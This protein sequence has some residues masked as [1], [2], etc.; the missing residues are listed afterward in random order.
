MSGWAGFSDEELRRIQQKDSTVSAPPVRGRKPASGNRSRQQLQRERALQSAAQKNVGAESLVL[1]REQQLTKPS[2]REEPKPTAPATTPTV[3]QEVQQKPAIMKH[4]E[5]DQP[6]T[7]EETPVVK[8]LDKQEIELREKTRL[9]QLQQEQKII[10]ERNKRKKALL[11]KTIAEKK[12]YE[13]A[14]AEYV[15]AKLDLHKKT[16]VKEQLTEHLCAIIQQNELRKAHKL[17]EL[18]QQLQLQASEEELERQ[19]EEERRNLEVQKDVEKE[20]GS[21]ESQEVKVESTKNCG[22]KEKET[23]KEETGDSEQ[24]CKTLENCLQSESVAVS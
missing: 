6:T 5:N 3:K 20:N 1:S 21:V 15:I 12:R 11:A 8:E 22:P 23:V 24:D 18:M 7:E 13:R 2:P 9:E 14:E 10:E 19:K 16:E 17:E 4:N